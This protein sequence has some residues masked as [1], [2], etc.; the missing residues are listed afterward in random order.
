MDKLENYKTYLT[1]V[2]MIIAAIGIFGLNLV[3]PDTLELP[4]NDMAT[5]LFWAGWALISGRSALQKVINSQ[6]ET[7]KAVDRLTRIAGESKP[8][9]RQD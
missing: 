8:G 9:V 2:L 1:G 7:A 4:T 3:A 5:A 6:A